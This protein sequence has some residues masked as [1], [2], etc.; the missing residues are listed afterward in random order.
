MVLDVDNFGVAVQ[1][2]G[3]EETNDALKHLAHSLRNRLPPGAAL[4]RQW[5]DQFVVVWPGLSPELCVEAAQDLVGAGA[6]SLCGYRT[7][8]CLAKIEALSKHLPKFKNFLTMSAGVAATQGLRLDAQAALLAAHMNMKQA[9]A[10]G[11]NQ[12]VG[13]TV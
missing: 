10:E 7:A 13:G 5:A 9:K 2:L 6:H 11:R 8:E 3:P 1:V 4:F 12:V